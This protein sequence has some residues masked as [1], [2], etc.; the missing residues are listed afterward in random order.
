MNVVKKDP[1]DRQ[2]PKDLKSSKSSQ[3]EKDELDLIRD[4]IPQFLL[5]RRRDL[6]TIRD[7]L[8]EGDFSTISRIGHA[9]KG[10]CRSYGFEKLEHLGRQLESVSENQDSKSV[11]RIC[12]EIESVLDEV[13]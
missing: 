13:T 8:N 7:A 5:N 6:V 1:Q 10:C 3:G 12:I 9:M 2:D 4:L 11:D